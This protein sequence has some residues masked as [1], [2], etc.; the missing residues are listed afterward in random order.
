MDLDLHPGALAVCRL[1]AADEL[2]AWARGDAKPLHAIVR[3]GDELSIT[4]AD[5]LVPEGVEAERGWRALAV[6]GP[7]DFGVTGVLSSLAVPLAA[8]DV[9][10]FVISTFDTD[11]LL[12]GEQHLGSA[13]DVLLDAG[14]RVHF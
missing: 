2:P 4:T 8:A 9:P 10:I 6:R 14:H 7:L 12:V 1:G 11:W 5:E 3:T 13:V